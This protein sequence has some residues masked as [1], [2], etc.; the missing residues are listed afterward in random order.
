MAGVKGKSGGSRSEA[1]RP[2]T[3]ITFRLGDAIAM[4]YGHNTP[5]EVGE[6]VEMHRGIPRTVVI[7]M[8][9]GEKVWI[10]IETPASPDQS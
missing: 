9:N 10:L 1:G 4:R 6:V 5:L 7:Q 2:P 8:R 3:S